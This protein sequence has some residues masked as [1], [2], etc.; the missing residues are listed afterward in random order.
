PLNAILGWNPILAIKRADDPEVKAVAQRIEQSAK[1]QLKMVNDL[2]DLGR[3]GTGILRITPRQMHLSTLIGVAVDA[4]RPAAAAK[5]LEVMV[6]S[7]TQ[8]APIFGD[9]DRLSQVIGN[10][11]SNALKFTPSGGRITLQLHEM[12]NRA[13]LS[14]SDTGQGISADLLPHV[15]DRFRQ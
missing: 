10:L 15:F 4:I 11:L 14:V 5:G 7:D 13:V 8:G 1:A 6:A 12:D 9:P 2:L 3:I